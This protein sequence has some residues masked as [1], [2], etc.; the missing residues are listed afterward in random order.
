VDGELLLA[1]PLEERRRK[2]LELHERPPEGGTTSNFVVGPG[3]EVTTVEALEEAFKAARGRRNEGLVVKR[4]DSAYTP[5]RRGDAW[6]KLKSHLPTL[7]VVVVG[8]ELGHGKRRGVLSD[9]TFAV[10][11]GEEDGELVTIGKAYT[12]LTDAE[13]AALTKRFVAETVE[14]HGR[15]RRVVPSVVLEV[16]FDQITKSERHQSGYAL[17]FPRI[18]RIREDKDPRDAD[19]LA[20]VREIYQSADNLAV[21]LAGEQRAEAEPEGGEQLELF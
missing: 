19:T 14:E 8:A 6:M 7:D 5:G 2:L 10:R 18:V 11:R 15:Y 13:I 12:G 17:R 9:V 21:E 4:L 16:A 20:R 3:V 1:R